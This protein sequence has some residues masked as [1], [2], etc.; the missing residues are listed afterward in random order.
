MWPSHCAFLDEKRRQNSFI[1]ATVYIYA[2]EELLLWSPASLSRF[3]ECRCGLLQL[4]IVFVCHAASLCEYGWMD[5]AS[6]WWW[7]LFGNQGTRKCVLDRRSPSFRHGFNAA[8]SKL[9]WPPVVSVYASVVRTGTYLD[10]LL[11]STSCRAVVYVSVS[12]SFVF[13]VIS[14][15]VSSRVCHRVV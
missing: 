9:L 2:H 4:V 12:F 3:F 10:H 13:P 11:S 6:A 15:Y 5:H 1:C 8:F 14:Q 7:W